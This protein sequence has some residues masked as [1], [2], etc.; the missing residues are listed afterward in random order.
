VAAAIDGTNC[1]FLRSNVS[2]FR[3]RVETWTLP[4]VDGIGAQLQ[5]GGGGEIE[6]VAIKYGTAAEVDTWVAEIESTQGFLVSLTDDWDRTFT[7][8]L[9]IQVDPP[10]KTAEM[11]NGGC[12]AEMR[13]RG[14][15]VR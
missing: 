8:V 2:G 10:S 7:N 1:D 5:G 15:G 3:E 11:G 6:L 4:G 13:I 9:I 12:R 14:I